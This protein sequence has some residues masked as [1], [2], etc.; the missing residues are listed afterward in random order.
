MERERTSIQTLSKMDDNG[1]H[2]TCWLAAGQADPYSVGLSAKNG[3]F[4]LE[5]DGFESSIKQLNDFFRKTVDV[6]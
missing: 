5:D 2:G 3:S 6:N 1:I 4:Y